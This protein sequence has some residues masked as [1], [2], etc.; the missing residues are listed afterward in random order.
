[1]QPEGNEITGCRCDRDVERGLTEGIV[2]LH[3]DPFAARQFMGEAHHLARAH[4]LEIAARDPV[5][6]LGD[7]G[8]SDTGTG[9]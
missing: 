1:M 6:M 8:E 5:A 2:L 9:A 7:P 4:H 3:A